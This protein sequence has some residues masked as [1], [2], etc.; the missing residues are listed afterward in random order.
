M[1][2]KV[3]SGDLVAMALQGKFDAIVHGCNC[4]NVMGAGIAPK[5]AKAFK[6]VKDADKNF[7]IPVGSIDRLGH[8]SISSQYNVGSKAQLD[9]INA[10]T[11]YGYGDG[12]VHQVNYRAIRTIFEDLDYA[13]EGQVIG[14]PKIGAGLA[15][16]HWQA[17]E[18]IINLV[19]P[20][21]EIILVEYNG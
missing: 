15:G 13:Y 17:I 7:K 11:Q 21:V 9:V 8:Y 19:T 16:G 18:T 4:H 20:N 5:I 6:G 12:A 1:I 2:V 14:I 3:V 10:Y